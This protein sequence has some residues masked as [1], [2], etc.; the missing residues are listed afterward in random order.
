MLVFYC[1]MWA[2]EDRR[3]FSRVYIVQFNELFFICIKGYVL[4]QL[5]D[6]TEP[7]TEPIILY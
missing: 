7:M 4:D 3:I 6:C 5:Q 2:A 1:N